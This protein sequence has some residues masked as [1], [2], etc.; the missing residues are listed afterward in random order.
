MPPPTP[1][2][3]PGLNSVNQPPVFSI[4]TIK[5]HNNKNIEAD[6]GELKG[7]KLLK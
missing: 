5:Q 7:D 4:N 1:G 6:W 3:K 2:L